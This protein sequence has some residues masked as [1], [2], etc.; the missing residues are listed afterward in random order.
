MSVLLLVIC[1][2]Y[3]YW[4]LIVSERRYPLLVLLGENWVLRGDHATSHVETDRH[5]S[6]GAIDGAGG[7]KS[8]V[9][10]LVRDRVG[11]GDDRS[12]AD[13]ADLSAGK[14]SGEQNAI[15]ERLKGK[16]LAVATDEFGKERRRC[17]LSSWKTEGNLSGV[18]PPLK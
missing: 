6:V 13:S 8:V 3:T 14:R 1:I 18:L 9:A 10:S 5:N 17:D 11:R 2:C 7:S 4:I 15:S 16:H 12:W